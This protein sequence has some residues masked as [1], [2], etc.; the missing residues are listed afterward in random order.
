MYFI[1]EK[2]HILKDTHQTGAAPLELALLIA[3]WLTLKLV[4]LGGKM[5]KLK[6]ENAEKT[7]VKDRFR[8]HSNRPEKDASAA[9][10][11]YLIRIHL[12]YIFSLQYLQ[13]NSVTWFSC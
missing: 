9:P 8:K 4:L 12:N 2:K 10:N 3:I 6:Y 7:L 13:Y 11:K 5:A 1:L